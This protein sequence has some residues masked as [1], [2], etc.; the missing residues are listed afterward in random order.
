MR[1]SPHAACGRCR[2]TVRPHAATGHMVVGGAGTE[3]AQDLPSVPSDGVGLP[4]SRNVLAQDFPSGCIQPPSLPPSPDTS[5]R[6][7]K[8]RDRAST[9]PVTARRARRL[10]APAG[11]V[12][13]SELL[14][15]KWAISGPA[16]L[17]LTWTL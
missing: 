8:A 2:S 10:R 14:C 7:P 3:A 5:D 12:V 11:A 16:C 13:F 17:S 4:P 15:A 9:A 6:P 1:C